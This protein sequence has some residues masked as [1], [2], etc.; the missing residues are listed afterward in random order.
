MYNDEIVLIVKYT[1][2]PAFR[3]KRNSLFVPEE[4]DDLEDV[5]VYEVADEYGSPLLLSE[6]SIDM[7]EEH[8]LNHIKE[9]RIDLH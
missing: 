1:Y 3:G 5:S 9:H 6:R 8:I 2:S 7:I 4:P